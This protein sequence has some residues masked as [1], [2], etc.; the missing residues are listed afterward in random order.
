MSLWNNFLD[1]IAKPLGSAIASGAKQAGEFLGSTIASPAQ[2]ITNIIIPAGTNIGLAN[3]GGKQLTE[4]ARKG[5]SENLQ[6]E[7]FK[8]AQSN[9]ILLRAAVALEENVISPAI[10]RPISTFGL[11][12]DPNSPL[13]QPGAYEKGFQLKDIARAYNRSEFVTPRQALVKSALVPAPIQIMDNAILEGLGNTEI[14]EIDLWNDEDIYKNFVENPVGRWYTGIGDFVVGNAAILVATK[15]AGVPAKAALRRSG[16][17]TRSTSLAEYERDINDN[18][19]FIGTNGAQGRITARGAEIDNIAKTTDPNYIQNYVE[20]NSNN[21]ALIPLLRETTDPA[22]VRDLILAD[23]GYLP[24]LERLSR[25]ESAKLAELG[26]LPSTL[27]A[28]S[29]LDNEIYQPEGDALARIRTAFDDLIAKNPEFTRI[30]DAFFDPKGNL[31]VFGRDAYIPIEPVFGKKLFIKASERAKQIS[32]ASTT[33]DF[34][35]VG[36]I[37]EQVL[38]SGRA[39]GL[40]ARLI[41]FTG[42]YKPMGYVTFSGA[43]PLDGLV[44]IDSFFDDISIFKNGATQ[45]QIAPG[46]FQS[47]ADYRNEFKSRYMDARTDLERKALLNQ[48]DEKL[49]DDITRTLG[50]YSEDV[51]NYVAQIKAQI[52]SSHNAI[53][54]KGFGI[55]YNGNAVMTEPITQSLLADSHRLVPWNIIEKELI[56]V[57]KDSKV[58]RGVISAAEVNQSVFELFNKYW[59]FDV[60]AR[61]TYIVKQSWAEP[62]LSAALSEGFTFLMR[63]IP[64]F[65]K[66]FLR[67]TRNRVSQQVSKVANATEIKAVNVAVENISEE[68]DKAVQVLDE[69]L[70]EV[71][72]MMDPQLTSPVTR[73]NNLPAVTSALKKAENIVDSLELDLRNAVKPYSRKVASVPTIAGLQRRIEYIEKNAPKDFVAR[74]ASVIA[75]AKAAIGKTK[76]EINTL[77][78]DGARLTALYEEVGKVYDKI[79]NILVKELGE[80]KAQQAALFGKSA[81]YK[82]RYYGRESDYRM[83]NGQWINIPS[84]FNENNLGAAL[85]AEFENGRTVAA[86]YLGEFL[87]GTRLNGIVRRSPGGI[88]DVQSPKYFDELAWVVN[89]YM[90]NDPMIK[91]ILEGKDERTLLEWTLSREGKAYVAQWGDVP[92]G[93]YMDFIKN[94]VGFVNR[95]LPNAQS[96][97][98]VLGKEVTAVELQGA[99]AK[100]IDRLTAIQPIDFNYDTAPQLVGKAPIEK[101][102]EAANRAMAK[103]WSVLTRPENPIRWAFADKVFYDVVARKANVLAQQGVE[104]TPATLNSLRASATREALQETE[105]TFYN[106]RRNNRALWAAR[107]LIAFPTASVNAFYRY[108]RFAI[109]NPARIAGFLHSYQSFY[110][111]FGI[112]KYGLPVEDPRDAVYI[113]IPGTKELGLFDGE[114]VRL[115]ARSIGFLL[116]YP[117]PSWISTVPV[118]WLLK[119]QPGA[120]DI[121]KQILGPTYDVIFPYGPPEGVGGV[122]ATFVPNWARDFKA[123][124]TGDEGRR[125]YLESVKSVANYYRALDD[126]GISK[127]PGMEKVRKD[128]RELYRIKAQNAAASIFGVPI[129]VDTRPTLLFEQY[130]DILVNKWRQQGFT[131]EQARS[132]AGDEF[133][134]TVSPDFPLD[135]IT[136]KGSTAKFFVPPTAEAW[137]RVMV[138]NPSLVQ[139]LYKI[140]PEL[141]GLMTVDLDESKEDFNLSVYR[142]LK[143]PNT[144]LPTG[145][146]INEITL[147]PEQ[148]EERRQINRTRAKYTQMREYLNKQAINVFKKKS[149]R[150]VPELQQALTQYADTVLKEENI[151]WWREWKSPNYSDKTFEWATG[152]MLLSNNPVFMEYYGKRSP[153]WR[154]A[155]EFIDIREQAA[156]IYHSFKQGDPKKSEWRQAWLGAIEERL[157]T[158]HPKLQQIIVNYFE[159]DQ[160]KR[161][162]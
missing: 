122:A 146:L 123:Y 111:S 59:S 82:K 42:S 93:A 52:T 131:S 61:P 6:Y 25:N 32:A 12:T 28:K 36:G 99:L 161:V 33:R 117:S 126:M 147:T 13:Y 157:S 153:F 30:R 155:K 81:E 58:K 49:G 62:I 114:G 91:L 1:N 57:S 152:I 119:E 76:G 127:F 8:S 85:R 14:D 67:N 16:L 102:D 133:L 11:V 140:N 50:L 70:A 139:E 44:E 83:I 35:R 90:R 130:Y 134:Q 24:A 66:N 34:S 96:R 38:S 54:R 79:D 7:A 86:T 5:I 145:E 115:N 109:K 4:A 40:T 68:L 2:G 150:N 148:E 151:D 142:L 77:M 72:R 55:D 112:D 84:L 136:F 128:A 27:R 106:I 129:K 22:V 23:K 116:N 143:N 141:V 53:A 29:A 51:R 87:T 9:D 94:R 108:G 103:V 45:I 71:D 39:G 80:K 15:G 135:R 95:Y 118:A 104:I 75:N 158:Y 18:L 113:L 154:D 160:L 105:K 69:L 107:T 46:K 156:N 124:L 64:T 110:R 31:T 41:R 149:I 120:E 47:A 10:T 144:K 98:L 97:N 162:K 92:K 78:P 100:D 121:F 21:P 3:M 159:D 56:R 65:T 43:R 19:L 137:S 63:E 37:S 125:D 74:N 60:L 88:V 89:R 48:L 73:A 132:M 17:T 26:D 20:A 138:D 101:V